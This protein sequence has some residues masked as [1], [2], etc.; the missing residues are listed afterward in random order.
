VAEE[1]PAHVE[2][3]VLHA[4]GPLIVGAASLLGLD[5]YL[6]EPPPVRRARIDRSRLGSGEVVAGSGRLDDRADG[7]VPA[8]PVARA[9]GPREVWFGDGFTLSA[10][11]SEAAARRTIERFIWMWDKES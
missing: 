6:A 7:P 5:T 3:Q 9:E 1:I 4:R 8:T 11:A 2:A 10:L